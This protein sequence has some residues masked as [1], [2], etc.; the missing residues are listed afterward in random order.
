MSRV[1]MSPMAGVSGTWPPPPHI[2]SF[3]GGMLGLPAS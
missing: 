2:L 3:S 1:L